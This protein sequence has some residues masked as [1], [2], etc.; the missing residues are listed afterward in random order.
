[1]GAGNAHLQE[2]H[3]QSHQG[4]C[5]DAIATLEGI[6]REDLDA[7]AAESQRRAALAI[8]EGRFDRSLI[9]VLNLDGTVALD[10]EEFPRPQTT[11][12]SLAALAPS[13]PADRRLPPTRTARPSAS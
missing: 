8:A 2:L 1:M 6:T 13:F 11:A 9:P 12:E 5:A 7:L 10:H 4:V 3:P